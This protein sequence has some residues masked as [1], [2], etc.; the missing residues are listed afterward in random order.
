MGEVGNH[1]D[2]RPVVQ[3]RQQHTPAYLTQ[4]LQETQELA[5]ANA[6]VAAAVQELGPLSCEPLMLANWQQ[7]AAFC[8][9]VFRT[10]PLGAATGLHG[11]DEEVCMERF[12]R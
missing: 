10:E 8:L 2:E 7:T 1:S 9:S 6:A 5:T 3:Q 4:L 11:R 12:V